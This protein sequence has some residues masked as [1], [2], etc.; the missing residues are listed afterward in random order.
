MIAR[1]RSSVVATLAALVL[2]AGGLEWREAS[3]RA[4]PLAIVVNRGTPVRVAPYGGAS[5]A[6]TVDAG[7]A[8]FVERRYG[9]WLEVRRGDGVHGW[10]LTSEVARL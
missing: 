6:A 2:V 9:P 1:R 3:R 10:V 8:L 5:A 7:A 4:R